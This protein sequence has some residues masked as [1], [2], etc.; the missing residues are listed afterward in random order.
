[1]DTRFNCRI[2]GLAQ[3]AG[4]AAVLPNISG[5]AWIT[6]LSYYGADPEDPFP[7]GYRLN[8]TWFAS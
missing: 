7:E 5:R 6:G 4:Q 2:D 8:D 3:V 1:M